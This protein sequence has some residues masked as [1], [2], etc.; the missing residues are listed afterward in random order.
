MKQKLLA[1]FTVVLACVSMCFTTVHAASSDYSFEMNYRL[2]D[3]SDLGNYHSLDE[4][5]VYIKGEVKVI[6]Y[7]PGASFK[8]TLYYALIRK[9]LGPDKNCGSVSY[10]NYEDPDEEL[11]GTADISS[12]NYYLQIFKVNDDGY[13]I[14][15]SGKIYN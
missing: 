4:G 8:N 11:L 5:D 1:V 14:A 13:D 12:G 2:V 9:R 7:A 3:G 10:S 6:D 15:G